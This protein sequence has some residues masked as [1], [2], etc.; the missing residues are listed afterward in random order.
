[1]KMKRRR[2]RK[3]SR[4]KLSLGWLYTSRMRKC[5]VQFLKFR[6][7]ASPCYSNAALLTLPLPSPPLSLYNIDLSSASL[8]S[9]SCF[10]PEFIASRHPRRDTTRRDATWNWHGTLK[11]SAA[12]IKH[13]NLN[14]SQI[15]WAAFNLILILFLLGIRT[16]KF[17]NNYRILSDL[18]IISTI[19]SNY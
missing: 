13:C 4:R 1:M 17:I 16:S 8:S 7:V 14:R 10:L 5:R 6:R 12:D 15:M 19:C 2:S 9:L 3:M 18:N 11:I